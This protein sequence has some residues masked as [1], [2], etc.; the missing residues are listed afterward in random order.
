M[1]AEIFLQFN[2][3]PIGEGKFFTFHFVLHNFSLASKG[4]KICTVANPQ[5][6]LFGNFFSAKLCYSVTYAYYIAC[7]ARFFLIYAD[8]AQ[9][10]M[11]WSYCVND[12]ILKLYKMWWK[13][14]AFRLII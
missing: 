14:S 13:N 8:E 9:N 6:S 1:S 4:W 10:F 3:V 2:V 5:G 12:N 11:K 7:A